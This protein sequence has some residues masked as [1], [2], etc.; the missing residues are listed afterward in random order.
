M[1]NFADHFPSDV[2][3]Q[4]MTTNQISGLLTE[5]CELTTENWKGT[6]HPPIF[7]ETVKL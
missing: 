7:R 6:P 1:S 3:N 4:C 2:H 5:N